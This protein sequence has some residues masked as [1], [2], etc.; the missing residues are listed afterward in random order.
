[1]SIYVLNRVFEGPFKDTFLLRNSP[2]VYVILGN[3]GG[4]NWTV[5]DVGESQD[6]RQRVERHDRKACW[7]LQNL[8]NLAVAAHYPYDEHY[9]K[10]LE[11][12]IR[13]FYNPP[14]GSK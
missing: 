4:E 7:Q 2:G 5:I 14:C 9:R 13:S 11:K 8:A 3:N 10:N 6:V 12:E 1:M